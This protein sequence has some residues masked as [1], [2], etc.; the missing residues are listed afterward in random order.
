MRTIQVVL[1]VVLSFVLAQHALAEPEVFSDAGFE[2]DKQAAVENEKL[3]VVYF[4]ASWCPPCKKMK[5]TTWMDESVV[6]WLGEHAVVTA[7][8][9]DEEPEIAQEYAISAMPTMVAVRAGEEVGRTVG[10]KG[11]AELSTWLQDP[12]AAPSRSVATGEGKELVR[13]KMAKAKEL[14][15]T[16][17]Y[18]EAT[19]L[20]VDLWETMLDDNPSYYGV[21]LSFLIGDLQTLANQHEPAKDAFRAIRDREQAKLASGD[22]TWEMLT[23]WV[24]L[25][26][27]VGGEQDTIEWVERIA[28][29]EGSDRTLARFADE[30]TEQAS[31][32]QRWDIVALAVGDP[33]GHASKGLEM[34]KMT[35][36]MLE[37]EGPFED[38]Q[39]MQYF[40]RPA[41]A[42]ALHKNDD[43]KSEAE[44]VAYLDKSTG[45]SEAWRAV[46]IAVAEECGKLRDDHRAWNDEFDLKGRYGDQPWSN[47]PAF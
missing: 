4:T 36:G 47:E 27:V 33:V 43:G 13:E 16:N 25:N 10:Y 28:R 29:K 30:I 15:F 14:L 24:H 2:A 20:Y 23:D 35:G 8:D 5:A 1:A 19:E 11:P 26:S 37:Q 31:R 32:V 42:A 39:S 46:F 45:D 34:L 38:V 21:R 12:S 6:S 22:V 41:I 40:L 3:H 9:V 17:K 44:L 18:E 7:V